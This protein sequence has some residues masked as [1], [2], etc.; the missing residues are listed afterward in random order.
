M[1]KW[2]KVF[3]F[4]L[5]VALISGIMAGC[6]QTTNQT[7]TNAG[8]TSGKKTVIKILQPG[9]EQ[10]D[11]LIPERNASIKGTYDLEA[12]LEK[13]LPDVDIQFVHIP[14][15]NW[16][17]ATETTVNSGLCDIA[18]YTNQVN[19]PDL[20]VPNDQLFTNDKT[21]TKEKLY[22]LFDSGAI[23]YT[24]FHALQKPA[25]TGIYYGLP[26]SLYTPQIF[27]DKKIF[28]DWGVGYITSKSTYAEILQ[29]A[30]QMTGINPKTGKKNYGGYISPTWSEWYLLTFNA[31]KEVKIPGMDITKMDPND[32]NY[33][34]TSK[35]VLDCFTW[36]KDMVNCSPAGVA[37]MEGQANWL[38]P[39]NDIAIMAGLINTS[40]FVQVAIGGNKEAT[41][42]FI[43]I[44]MPLSTSGKG[45][46][47][48]NIHYAVTK[49]SANPDKAW[50]VLKLMCTNKSVI[51]EIMNSG[52][53]GE[54]YPAIKDTSGLK[55]M[56][57]PYLKAVANTR[58]AAQF[59]TADY[60][61]WRQPALT[62]I[63]SLFAGEYGVD[64]ARTEL[65]TKVDLW[66][67]SVT[68]QQAKK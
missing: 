32:Y 8:S 63:N 46:M 36:M 34:G 50:E 57:L 47:P 9:S 65:Q 51:D 40:W 31:L 20:Y 3:S 55:C 43:P 58:P 48:L 61:Y 26:M 2:S 68:E 15:T 6:G 52:W 53:I 45:Y 7:T 33:F 22:G 17:P 59:L 56:E 1:K 11:I 25:S 16:I 29:K 62:V 24:E 64:K 5:V 30:K 49:S 37:T 21:T 28:D 41:D 13:L 10:K 35:E 38:T 42:R 60:W 27:Y 67:K 44:G 18:L 39:D 12:M 4:L 23:F 54:G 19:L 14:W 66:I